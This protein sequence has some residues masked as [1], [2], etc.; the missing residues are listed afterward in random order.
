MWSRT[1]GDSIRIAKSNKID[2]IFI[3][4]NI[5]EYSTEEAIRILSLNFP[6]IPILVFSNHFD[7]EIALRSVKCGAQDYL[8]EDEVS[9]QNIMRSVNFAIERHLW[10]SPRKSTP[11]DSKY[12]EDLDNIKATAL[13]IETY[14]HGL[15]GKRNG[16]LDAKNR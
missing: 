2:T 10:V 6:F 9:S 3:G 8:C 1:V 4:N 7:E 11:L 13:K 12:R 16:A 5:S 15:N 14:A